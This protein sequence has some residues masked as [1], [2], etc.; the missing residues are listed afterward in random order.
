MNLGNWEKVKGD[1]NKLK[2]ETGVVANPDII[3]YLEREIPLTDDQAEFLHN[4]LCW[5][6]QRQFEYGKMAGAADERDRLIGIL[7]NA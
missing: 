5:M 7:Q 6:N 1:L 3:K 4:V 2:K